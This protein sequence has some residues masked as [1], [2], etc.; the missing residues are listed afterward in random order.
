MDFCEE[1]NVAGCE[2]VHHAEVQGGELFSS[3]DVG[4]GG[5][6]E[7]VEAVTG[8]GVVD[9]GVFG[10]AFCGGELCAVD[11]V[12]NCDCDAAGEGPA[13]GHGDSGAQVDHRPVGE[14]GM[15]CGVEGA[16]GGD[17]GVAH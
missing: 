4:E 15:L 13:G 5:S 2:R 11:A 12:A 9:D 17:G 1:G 7:G 6:E 14:F 3:D 16:V 8:R 10:G